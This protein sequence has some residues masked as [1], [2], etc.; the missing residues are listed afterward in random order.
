MINF[1]IKKLCAI[2]TAGCFTISILNSNLFAS[3]NNGSSIQE[4]EKFISSKDKQQIESLFSEKYGKLLSYK[5]NNSDTVVINIQDLH[6]D[7]SVQKNI[8][9]LIEELSKKYKIDN[10]FVEG[11]IGTINTEILSMINP[12]YKKNVLENLLK[13][14][15]LTGTEYYNAL[16]NKTDFL[17][18]AEDEKTYLQNIVRLF[19]IISAKRETLNYLSKIENEIEFLKSK[20]LNSKNKRFNAVLDKYENGELSQEKFFSYLLK[21]AEQNNINLNKYK[22]LQTY[23]DVFSSTG[24]NNKKLSKEFTELI[25]EMKNTIPYTQYKQILSLTSNLTDIKA[26]KLVIDGYCGIKNLNLKKRFPNVNEFLSVRQNYSDF[27]PVELVKEERSLVDVVRTFLSET[28]TE[29]EIAYLGDFKHFYK[30]YITASLTS[31]QWEYVKLGLDKFKDLYAKYSISNEVSQLDGYSKLLSD[32]Y[33]TNL[34]RNEIFI[35]KMGLAKNV[36]RKNSVLSKSLPELLSGAKSIVV[37]VA[38]GYHTEGINEILNKNN[39]SNVTITPELSNSNA[40]TRTAYEN[41]VSQQAMSIK[42]M[43]ALGLI[44]NAT[45][46][47]QILAVVNSLFLNQSLDGINIDI[48]V[49]QLNRIFDQNIKVSL[50][51]ENQQLDFIFSDGSKQT[52]DINMDIKNVVEDQNVTELSSRQIVKVTGERLKEITDTVLKTT[53]N[54]GQEIF[55]PQIYQ[56]SKDVCLFMVNNK[57]YLGNGAIWEIANSSYNGQVLDGVEPVVYEYMPEVMQQALLEKQKDNDKKF[58]IKKV[59]DAAKKALISFM[60]IVTLFS[61]TACGVI[62]TDTPPD[63]PTYTQQQIIE[64]VNQSTENI[65]Y[66]KESDGYRFLSYNVNA[67]TQEDIDEW[68][69]RDFRDMSGLINTYDQSLVVVTLLKMGEIE[70]AKQT[71]NEIY[72]F[73]KRFDKIYKSNQEYY[74]ITGEIVWVGIAAVQ[75]KLATGST[76]YDE[77]ISAVDN[78]LAQRTS[79]YGYIFGS[80]ANMIGNGAYCST[81]HMLDVIAYLNLKTLLPD[82]DNIEADKELLLTVA[83]F[84]AEDLIYQDTARFMRGYR[85]SKTA[86][87]TYS[88]G[89]QVF[90]A[91]ERYNPEIYEQCG[92]GNKDL[93]KIIRNVERD[94]RIDF[95]NEKDTEYFRGKVSQ[96][97][98]EMMERYHLYSW[99]DQIWVDKDKKTNLYLFQDLSNSEINFSFE[100][101]LQMAATYYLLGDYDMAKMIL[102]DAT[103]LARELGFENGIFPASNL[104]NVYNYESYGWLVGRVPS[105]SATCTATLLEYSFMKGDPELGSPFYPVN[106][107]LQEQTPSSIL[108]QAI[109]EINS[110]IKNGKFSIKAALIKIINSETIKSLFSPVSFIDQ[111][112]NPSSKLG[113]KI[114]VSV[115]ALAAI[116]AAL[117]LSF[118]ALNIILVLVDTVAAAVFANVTTHMIIDFRYLK[119]SGLQQAIA[120]YGKDS[121]SLSKNGVETEDK[122]KVVNMYVINDRPQN[123]REFDFKPVST[124]IKTQDGKVVKC[125]LGRYNGVAVVFAQ[126]V[127]YESIVKE[128]TQTR[129]FESFYGRNTKARTQMKA[130]VDIIE[131][132]MANPDSTLRYGENGNIIVGANV[133]KTNDLLDLKKEFSLINNK[134]I[135]AI[136]VNQNV[137]VFIDEDAETVSSYDDMMSITDLYIKDTGLGTETKVLFSDKY[138]NKIIDLIRQDVSKNL[139]SQQEIE[140]EVRNRFINLVQTARSSNKDISVVF[141]DVDNNTDLTKYFE[142]G[143]FSYVANGKYFDSI[144]STMSQM[145][146]VTNLDEI[147][148][149]DGS[150]SVIKV[151]AFKNEIEKTSGIFTFLNTS[152]KIKEILEQRNIEFVK[153]AASNFEFNKMPYIDDN[154]IKEIIN[155]GDTNKYELLSKYLDEAGSVSMYYATLKGDGERKAF[156]EA[157][158]QRM[159]AVNL[160][161]AN[162]INL[163]LREHKLEQILA[164]ALYIKYTTGIDDNIKSSLTF[165]VSQMT[166]AQAEQA[167]METISRLA[168]E[169][170]VQNKPEAI[171]DIIELI[172][173]YADRNSDFRTESV[174]LIN[175]QNI[176]G[177]LSAA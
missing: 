30:G 53:F 23:L 104:N 177:I 116:I 160:L 106:D 24:Y 155:S 162:D 171:N 54:F 133:L 149:F 86:L 176:R 115:T 90:S 8:Y 71:L 96:E 22:T 141:E 82:N 161:R 150:L 41:L 136:T 164:K 172:P 66:F 80:E 113:A 62:K 37:L 117:I 81:E 87:D 27:N 107:P 21:F 126:G 43:I 112:V 91:L 145:R 59:I 93:E 105:L 121:V 79:K 34:N 33:D 39:I 6:C 156:I 95:N 60:I 166:A 32:F 45:Q 38:G 75:Y 52:I 158:L 64:Y 147:K 102:D 120:L 78:Y 26:L 69:K 114:L 170:F 124:K 58:N 140:Q 74:E 50:S 61:M 159:L 153:Q 157:I 99:S 163:G 89:L 35:N 31:A 165:D 111:H 56:I 98:Y 139:T 44:S 143:I 85:D 36:K 137:A 174:E 63:N 175:V 129:Q 46:K 109:N 131:I 49:Q 7:Y 15:R 14:G 130:N 4:F 148:S 94:F 103:V 154:V 67:M 152:L 127:S 100:W 151:S 28:Q 167:L 57:W 173:L 12:D 168:D 125:W 1:D 108:P 2:I 88:W 51:N 70:K 132:D 138:I 55:A 146:F 5:D 65:M 68:N 18:G 134:K 77:L 144:T 135:D 123:F 92:F 17:K 101:S 11:G 42:Q 3:V 169:A 13:S 10:V 97:Q 19:E 118:F 47:E 48:L 142:Y 40:D 84:T 25:N 9:S 110:L 20:Y 76:E 122:D 119:A 72:K 128:F 73:Y 16:N 29:L 83:S